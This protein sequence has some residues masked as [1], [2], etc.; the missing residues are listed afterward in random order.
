M[1]SSDDVRSETAVE[2]LPPFSK[3]KGGGM[4]W[5]EV[6]GA[7]IVVVGLVLLVLKPSKSGEKERASPSENGAHTPISTPENTEITVEARQEVEVVPHLSLATPKPVSRKQTGLTHV[8]AFAKHGLLHWTNPLYRTRDTINVG[9]LAT[10]STGLEE[11]DELVSLSL[12][13][14]EVGMPVGAKIRGVCEYT[15][16]REPR[17]A[18][19]AGA[20]LSHGLSNDD[21]KG[22]SLDLD[23]ATRVLRQSDV[24]LAHN[25]AFHR[26][27]LEP[28]FP[29]IGERCWI[30][31]AN[32]DGWRTADLKLG[33]LYALFGGAAISA[34]GALANR[35]ELEF[36]LFQ[37]T[38]KTDRD[39][40]Y[41]SRMIQSPRVLTRWQSEWL[42]KLSWRLKSS[43][44]ALNFSRA[45]KDKS[46]LMGLRLG[47][48]AKL[49]TKP[50][51][52]EIRAYMRG[53]VGGQGLL[54]SIR[55]SLN[56]DVADRLQAGETL[57]AQVVE[58][59]FRE[60]SFQLVAKQSRVAG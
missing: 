46:N 55:E 36:I 10:A 48:L 34:T 35:Y 32:T 14:V 20:R 47:D 52:E 54:F 1:G 12:S 7:A 43:D 17:G 28:I 58:A 25:A 38:S 49:W 8:S 57:Y 53:T 50:G 22:A 24:L 16:F 2:E 60:T 9:I 19:S 37:H 26:R 11:R 23:E 31:S 18:V 21:L 13:V 33:A 41:M 15:G 30:C 6:I 40:T 45:T 4:L 27:M 44:G 59:S 39:T 56:E 5:L 42:D 29:G 3:K 51:V